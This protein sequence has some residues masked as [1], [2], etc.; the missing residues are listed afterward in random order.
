MTEAAQL[1]A[2][3]EKAI[4]HLLF[5]AMSAEHNVLCLAD[6]PPGASF[7]AYALATSQLSRQEIRSAFM[8]L[9]HSGMVDEYLTSSEPLT[10][11][12]PFE[13]AL[14]VVAERLGLSGR[15]SAGALLNALSVSSSVLIVLAA[16]SIPERA[17]GGSS[18]IRDLLDAACRPAFRRQPGSPVPV[19][20]VG[21]PPGEL[22]ARRLKYLTNLKEGLAFPA[23]P[24]RERSVFFESQLKRFGEFRGATPAGAPEN[25][26]I[27]Q[28]KGHF[29]ADNSYVVFPSTLRMLGFLASN[30]T[31]LS[32]FDPT[33]GWL[34]Q[35]GMAPSALPVDVG[36]HLFEV[37]AHARAIKEGGKRNPS[38]RALRW[39]STA[40]YW[41]TEDA[42]EDLGRLLPRTNLESFRTA[43]KTFDEHIDLEQHENERSP[44]YKMD[45]ALRGVVQNRWANRDA[46]GRATVHHRIALRLFESSHSKELLSAEYPFRP[47]W[48][49]SRMHFLAECLRHLVRS[50]EQAPRTDADRGNISEDLDEF[51]KP[52]FGQNGK[53]RPRYAADVINYC[54]GQIYW[55]QLNANRV[56]GTIHNRKLSRQHGAYH[57]TAE[58][59]QLMSEDGILG[60][61]HWAL[62]PVYVQ[63]YLREVAYAQLDLGE[64]Q[65]AKTSFEMLIE[66]WRCEHRDPAEGIA[67]KL[68]LII[69]LSAM[70]DLAAARK[71]L[72]EVRA[73]FG[74]L[75]SEGG[76]SFA[77]RS[78]IRIKTRV[79]ARE[80][81]LRY[82]EGDLDGALQ[83][84]MRIETVNPGAIGRD[85]AHTYIATL[86][87]LGGADRLT[88][89]TAICVRNVFDNTTRGLHH[90]ALGFRVALGHAFRKLGMLDVAEVV[91]DQVYNDVQLYGCSERTY[92]ALL[93]E[94]GRIVFAQRR[95][96][97]A[98]AAYLRPCFDRA[99]SRGY[100]RHT[101]ISRRYARMCLEKMLVEAAES[102]HSLSEGT[103][104]VEL[105]GR[106][107]IQPNDGS[108]VDLDPSIPFDTFA[109][110]DWVARLC[111]VEGLQAELD[112]IRR[113]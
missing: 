112:Q 61:P 64:L 84:C 47:H 55:L 82:L 56:T 49:R 66:A 65:A 80:A 2:R 75:P 87:A 15:P 89:A 79:D 109:S 72:E 81:Q 39:C 5:M 18:Y 9:P 44:A 77:R 23:K 104:S 73:E 38:L 53:W 50:C 94:A 24:S 52:P 30:D 71:T 99:R 86:G 105:H 113:L 67:F 108:T 28:A 20:L 90:E 32:N 37:I 31:N 88:R 12:Q 17:L 98:Y 40:L 6:P 16:K 70:N 91:L 60:K 35:S 4:K 100:V 13:Q 21:Q 63:R 51:P 76:N 48:G 36:L 107:G 14:L 34:R 26:R 27:K 29:N 41:L 93:L 62:H 102:S 46:F 1:S 74:T 10:Y 110:D 111:S 69:A 19:I 43:I 7:L 54:F 101:E 8:I 106:G 11:D 103:L 97:R 95:L 42:A 58:L 22:R 85:V 3:E 45:M 57:L 59:L 83:A 78:R 33:S 92:L 96:A 68:D 25:A